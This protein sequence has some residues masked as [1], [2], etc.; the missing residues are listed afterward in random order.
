MSK[1]LKD[2]KKAL[3][4][5]Q[6]KM[7]TILRK[8]YDAVSADQRFWIGFAFISIVTTL[9]IYNPFWRTT[10]EASYRVGEIARETIVSPADIFFTDTEETE[11]R[12]KKEM[13]AVKPI[14]VV[15]P[16]RQEEAVQSF[17][18]AWEDLQRKAPAAGSQNDN[19]NGVIEWTGTGGVELGK[20]FTSRRFTANEIDSVLRV[21]RESS[22]GDI[23]GDQDRNY[24]GSSI[25]IVDRQRPTETREAARPMLMMTALSEARNRLKEGIGQIRSL[26]E[27]EAE[28]FYAATAPLIQPSL[29]Y[30]S[31]ATD[32]ARK[33]AAEAVEPVTIALKRGQK[34]ADVGEPVNETMMLQ[35]AAIR[36][37]SA[38]SR[39][40]NRFFGLLILITVLFW[41]AWKFIEHRGIVPRL[42]L[43]QQKTFALFCFIVFIQTTLMAIF[44]RLA[45]FTASQNIRAP[46]ND[47]SLWSFAI[48]F[49]F[50]SLLMA[51][52]AD[53][54]TALFTG[55][56]SAILAGF[57]A[58][59]S[60]EF[61]VYAII[62]SSVAAY[63]IGRYRSRQTVTLAGVLVGLSS[64][65]IAIALLAFSQQPLILNTILLVI[66][67]GLAGGII[68]SAVTAVFL[69]MCETLFGVLTDVKLLELSNADL[70]VLGQL[71]LRAPG[72]NQHSHAVGQLAEEACRVVGGNALLARIGALYHD[73]GKTAAPEH[74]VENQLG[75]NPHDRLKPS[76]SA[77]IIISH[78]TY[79]AK[80]AREM[81]LPQRIID[82]IPQHHGTRTLH[83]FLKKAQ[84]EARDPDEIS[85]ND[86]RYPGPK[87]QFREAAIMMIADSCEAAARSL[88][89][90][91][92]E[93]IRFI[94]TKIIDAILSDDQLDECD[95]TLREL[96]QIRESMIRSLVAIYHSR[97]DYP[98]YTPP[99]SGQF[100]INEEEE[101]NGGKRGIRYMNP[102]DI[103]ISKGGEIEDEAIDRTTEPKKA[104]A[105][106]TNK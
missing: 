23:Y 102:A 70:P 27:E 5:L 93:N 91:T 58:P 90:P 106:S 85:E 16:K 42:A 29:I 20:I 80:L 87:P 11:R 84:A 39:Q 15:E 67:C 32:A 38:S 22:G 83:Y 81:G 40:L 54:R 65:G 74:F 48:P 41:I 55:I 47:A 8:P 73:I 34:I 46:M 76:Q 53:R 77:K 4:R 35:M 59:R 56:F 71:A 10:G 7:V 79:G 86:F 21:L 94:V 25:E 95:L 96:T 3:D 97:V 98:G 63:G 92:P 9:L 49:A 44:F 26:S 33:T 69:P 12:R 50:G 2:E 78:V 36:D 104:D 43:S 51:L 89:E 6:D 62:V 52:L 28:A 14:F 13:A 57:L 31:S 61:V 17:R 37:Y 103:P 1:R 101:D 24:L 18:A 19:G 64:A 30:D 100:K 88:A 45:E 105:R 72:T 99:Q 75:K 66:A 82:F 68:T 60:L